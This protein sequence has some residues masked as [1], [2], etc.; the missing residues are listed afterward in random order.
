MM[1]AFPTSIARPAAGLSFDIAANQRSTDSLDAAMRMCLF[2]APLLILV[3]GQTCAIAFLHCSLQ[4][5]TMMG[6]PK[7]SAFRRCRNDNTFADVSSI[8]H[9][10]IWRKG[11]MMC[12]YAELEN[13]D[14]ALMPVRVQSALN[15]VRQSF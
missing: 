5:Q 9:T 12:L 6:C 3:K 10:K 1:R 13:A 15:A 11:L 7:G 8:G 4:R 2:L 14:S